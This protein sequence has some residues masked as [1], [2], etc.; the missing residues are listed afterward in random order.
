LCRDEGA[1]RRSRTRGLRKSA[2]APT[3]DVL[4]PVAASGRTD[5]GYGYDRLLRVTDA[6][7]TPEGCSMQLHMEYV[8]PHEAI[9]YE[10]LVTLASGKLDGRGTYRYLVED[11]QAADPAECTCES[12][13][14]IEGDI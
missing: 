14:T 6:H 2:A 13:M 1:R 4:A 9:Q 12:A 7:P 11:C 5:N 10:A 8:G 3:F